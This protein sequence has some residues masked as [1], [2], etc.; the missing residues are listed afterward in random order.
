MGDG[1]VTRPGAQAASASG[2]AMESWS[3]TRVVTRGACS[4]GK[5]LRPYVGESADR[6]A[7]ADRAR[8]SRIG[9]VKWP[10]S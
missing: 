2:S 6:P 9:G 10:E 3:R 4:C 1:G 8:R 7:K 5:L